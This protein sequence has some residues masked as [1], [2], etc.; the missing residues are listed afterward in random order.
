[1]F[2]LYL[3]DVYVTRLTLNKDVYAD[4]GGST[5]VVKVGFLNFPA[6]EVVE[7]DRRVK[8]EELFV[9]EFERGQSCHF[10]MMSDQLVKTMKRVK[11]R[12]GVFR[13]DD[14]FPICHVHTYVNGC[15]CD[16]GLVCISKPAPFVFKGPFDLVDPGNSFAGQLELVITVTNLGRSLVTPYGLAPNCFV[17][18]N[19]SEGPEYKCNSK[20]SQRLSERM[21]ILNGD[22]LAS[23][24]TVVMDKLL[25]TAAPG[26]LMRDVAGISPV[27]DRL[28]LGSPP[29]KLP[30]P[31]LEDPTVVRRKRRGRKGRKKK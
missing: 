26:N 24:E 10:S 13:V 2:A 21:N 16:L 31:P 27:A 15:A 23:I 22:N 5:L 30:R 1:M 29:P 19:N 20:D 9:Y 8:D 4:T 6:T 25:D 11:L 28:A 12:I 17:F 18:K 14:G 7:R 3:L